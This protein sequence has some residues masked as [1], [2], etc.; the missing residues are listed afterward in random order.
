MNPERIRDAL[1]SQ[2]FR[3]FNLVLGNGRTYTITH[4]DFLAI[5]PGPFARDLVFWTE[6]GPDRGEFQ[7][8]WVNLDQVVELVAPADTALASR[9][10][11]DNGA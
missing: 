10:A 9:P 11:E 3:P 6:L 1:K 2:P 7:T 5:P 8:H 4:P